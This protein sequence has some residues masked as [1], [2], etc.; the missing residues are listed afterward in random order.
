MLR[1][2]A[3]QASVYK[4]FPNGTWALTADLESETGVDLPGYES[5]AMSADNLVIAIGEAGHLYQGM[6]RSGKSSR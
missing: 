6:P 5:L 3:M 4:R 2:L 1:V